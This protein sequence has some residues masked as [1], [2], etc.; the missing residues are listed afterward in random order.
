MAAG[1]LGEEDSGLEYKSLIKEVH[2]EVNSGLVY[3]WKITSGKK[4]PQKEKQ[5]D[6]GGRKP[7]QGGSGI[8]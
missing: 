6:S 8:L 2:E 1:C 3:I 4:T 7:R 5:S